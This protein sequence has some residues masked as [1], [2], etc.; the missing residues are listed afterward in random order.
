MANGERQADRPVR[1][2][3][4]QDRQAVVEVEGDVDLGCSVQ[5][6]RVLLR[7]LDER[8]DRVVV[9]L[10]AV[11][12]MDSSGVASLVKLLSS[13]KRQGTE[14]RLAALTPRVRSIFEITR[15]ETV[16]DI[17]ATVAEATT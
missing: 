10:G 7:V 17:R 6:Q 13:A 15:L 9:D 4:W 12:Y 5:F 11:A 8:P 2:V 1:A 3:R 16:F 14:V